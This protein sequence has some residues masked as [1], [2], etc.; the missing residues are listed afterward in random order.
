MP[1]QNKTIK[2][3]KNQEKKVE[4]EAST[5]IPPVLNK[6]RDENLR[7]TLILINT[8]TKIPINYK[9]S[10]TEP[11]EIEE[12]FKEELESYLNEKYKDIYEKVSELRERGY[13]MMVWT[14]KL[15]AIPLK[16]KVFIST[17]DKK[18]FNRI[19]HKINEINKGVSEI[20][21]KIRQKEE[22]YRQR[23][24]AERRDL[25]KKQITITKKKIS[26]KKIKK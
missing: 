18:D 1:E 16:I 8:S 15:M 20:F 12:Y 23:K 5:K 14:F 19:T 24:I 22:L 13:D 21:E 2:I 17:C 6:I 10:L 25:E 7:E 3:K 9:T 4:K 11:K 26:K